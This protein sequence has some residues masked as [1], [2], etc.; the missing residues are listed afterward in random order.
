MRIFTFHINLSYHEFMPFY[1]G[2][3]QNIE[4]KDSFQQ[5]IWINGRHFRPFFTL[6]GVK[7]LFKLTLDQRGN[8]I[9]LHKLE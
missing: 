7:G 8:I 4:V 6:N 3:I 5:V 9:S 2:Q 1:Q